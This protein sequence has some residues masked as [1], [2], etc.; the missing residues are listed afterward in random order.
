M[1]S[2]RI[3]IG[4]FVVL[5][6]LTADPTGTVFAA[7]DPQLDRKVAVKVLGA[8]TDA[9]DRE[10][11][12]LARLRH[13]NVV[14]VHEVGTHRGARF[15]AMDLVDG[16]PLRAWL[17]SQRS[18]G[19]ILDLLLQTCSALAAAHAVGIVHRSFDAD[20]VLVEHGR[21]R[22][23]GFATTVHDAS[24]DEA[25]DQ[26][27]FCTTMQEA[28]DGM[29]VPGGLRR[30]V[31]RGLA[32]DPAQR[33]PGMA[34]LLHE[35]TRRRR[36]RPLAILV[37]AAALVGTS[38]GALAVSASHRDEDRCAPKATRL[39]AIWNDTIAAEIGDAFAASDLAYASDTWTRAHDVIARWAESWTQQHREAWVATYEHGRQ[40]EAMFDARMQCLDHRLDELASLADMLAH[41]DTAV[42]SHAVEATTS[43]GTLDECA[44]VE[45]LALRQT[46][47]TTPP[48]LFAELARIEASRHVGRYADVLPDARALAAAADRE[49]FGDLAPAAH[50]ACA[51][52]AT[53]T[54]ELDA[55]LASARTAIARA[56]VIGDDGRRAE[57]ELLLINLLAQRH[58]VELA[59]EW[60]PIVRG[61]LARLG[62]PLELRARLAGDEGYALDAAGRFAEALARRREALELRE[63][64]GDEL[65]PALAAAH[66]DLAMTLLRTGARD[67]ARDHLVLALELRTRA[68]G[69]LHPDVADAH[70]DLGGLLTITGDTNGAVH[71][72]QLAIDVATV[73]L[74][75]DAPFLGRTFINL[76]NAV[77][78]GREPERA[79]PHYERGIAILERARGPDD[80]EVGIALGNYG[81]LLATMAMPGPPRA[82]EVLSRARSIVATSLG[83]EHPDL[84]Y[85]DNHLVMAHLAAGQL[86]AAASA[87]DSAVRIATATHGHSHSM[88]AQSLMH[89]GD[90]EAARHDVRAAVRTYEEALAIH[91]TIES[92][93]AELAQIRFQLAKATAESGQ[94][95][96]AVSLARVAREEFLAD[97]PELVEY[98]REVDAWLAAHE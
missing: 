80:A 49:G 41:P 39:D 44:D 65:D 67:E 57:A 34:E 42:V 15:I 4:R 5:A 66:S 89:R 82:I 19:P 60:V 28:L 54:G 13:P 3:R 96:R 76:G 37:T 32:A 14:A 31:M 1:S 16:V 35:L 55:A 71:E 62:E 56:D 63:E 25:G 88:V 70:A 72:L 6:E 10:A 30:A 20:A 73:A 85:I 77:A 79:A 51:R 95:Q 29:R 59:L 91:A 48:A 36:R 12:A 87:A 17:Q 61:T 40:S 64:L 84:C 68:L 74:G 53:R 93:A 22:V 98:V 52:L 8:S 18:S 81:Q 69:E 83:P 24:T 38:A 46:E 78:T 45:A 33:W 58:H 9:T 43:L 97:A 2:E 11:R 50:L 90:V 92:R 75:P 86:D 47:T 23:V 21:A 27:A 26:L 7:Y 94:V